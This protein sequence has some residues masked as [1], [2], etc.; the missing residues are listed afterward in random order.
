MGERMR[1]LGVRLRPHVKTHK[2]VEAARLQVRGHFG[3]ITVST[4]AE[5]E[6]FAAAG[7]RDITYAFPLAIPAIARA[8]AIARTVEHLH[9]LVDQDAVVT[10][11]RVRPGSRARHTQRVS[12][13]S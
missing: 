5:A 3:G 11:L 2:C 13:C 6:F 7:F 10:A 12:R 9:V 1:R 4:L 8:A